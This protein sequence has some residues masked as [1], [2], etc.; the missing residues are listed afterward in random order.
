M[1]AH[2]QFSHCGP[3]R[4][5][6]L[7]SLRPDR[8]NIYGEFPNKLT[9]LV[10]KTKYKGKRGIE[11]LPEWFKGNGYATYGAG[12]VF[13]EN[14]YFAYTNPA[15][16]TEPVYTWMN[17]R[18]SP[19]FTKPYVGSWTDF[20]EA[21]DNHFSDGQLADFAAG[22]ITDKLASLNKP[23]LFIV[24]FW[25]PHLPFQ[26]PKQYWD[27]SQD[28]EPPKA[29]A[30]GIINFPP[31]W[32]SIAKGDA[33]GEVGLYSGIPKGVL[34]WKSPEWAQRSAARSYRATIAYVDKQM[35]KVLDA[36]RTSG[37]MDQ[38]HIVFM[39]DHGFHLGDKGIYCKH[40]NF[41]QG[42]R[43]P[44]VVVPALRERHWDKS[45]GK[46]A[47]APV[48]LLDL[49]PTLADLAQLP[50]KFDTKTFGPYVWQGMS[51]RPVL[52]QPDSGYLKPF[53]ISQYPRGVGSS[54]KMGYTFR[55]T[56]YRM[57]VWCPAPFTLNM[58]TC[59]FELYD[60]ISDQAETTNM[61]TA[62][63]AIR[64]QI[65]SIWNTSLNLRDPEPFDFADH[66]L[67]QGLPKQ[68]FP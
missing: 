47:Y 56:R 25:K 42:V 36:L 38:T 21:E 53:A 8:T 30:P 9:N 49:L 29:G 41:E 12:K 10:R 59:F 61:A 26:C 6:F 57:T 68:P 11:T 4:A 65:L 37:Q 34:S 7:T 17:L 58:K 40:T 63:K 28:E 33:C 48:E 22:F 19:S 43:V 55:T 16:W 13:H 32:L 45:R 39:G 24:G 64:D 23:W 51:L 1:N 18:R 50:L 60:F 15:Y 2:A 46:K 5:S 14:E 44:F 20:P 27:L 35:G 66:L 31:S 62:K 52:E 54:R 3:S 67:V